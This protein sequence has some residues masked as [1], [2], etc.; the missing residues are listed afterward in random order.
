MFSTA[1]SS[2]PSNLHRTLGLVRMI[3]YLNRVQ[4]TTVVLSLYR[5]TIP[6]ELSNGALFRNRL[7][8]P[9]SVID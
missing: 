4:F 9:F 1:L 2:K 5:G 3:V 6:D 8:T 7:K